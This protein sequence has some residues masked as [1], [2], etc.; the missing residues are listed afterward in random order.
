M[1]ERQ[2][3]K[4]E[5]R[6]PIIKDNDIIY[7]YKE[8]VFTGFAPCFQDGIYSLAC[9]KGAKNGNG[10]RQSVC[11]S[12]ESGKNVWVMAVAACDIRRKDYNISGIAYEPGDVIYL[13]KIDKVCTWSEYSTSSVYSKRR[14]SYYVL[15]DGKVTWRKKEK[16]LHDKE[17]NKKTDCG[18]G[19]CSST[20]RTE[21]DVFINDKQILLAKEYYVFDKGQ[22]LSGV[23]D[24]ET[25]DVH[26][27]Y[28]YIEKG[29][30]GRA[31]VLKEFLK[32]N[33]TFKFSGG[34]DPFK[35][36]GISK[37]GGCTRK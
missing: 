18:I 20:R 8:Q 13:A 31:S 2:L 10:M 29:K 12:F 3:C 37:G 17:I 21:E 4:E 11:K 32:K 1:N 24:Y 16:D 7:T 6:N 9:C 19:S 28:S 35:N 25:L 30:P 22:R 36:T 14:D 23:A 27:G 15:K 33:H 34:A 5:N 26:R